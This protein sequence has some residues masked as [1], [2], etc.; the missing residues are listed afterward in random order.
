MRCPVCGDDYDDRQTVGGGMEARYESN[1]VCID[2]AQ[3]RNV[4]S[5]YLHEPNDNA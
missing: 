3:H 5:V 1:R 2:M 4:A